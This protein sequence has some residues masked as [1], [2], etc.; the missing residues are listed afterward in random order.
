[1]KVVTNGFAPLYADKHLKIKLRDCSEGTVFVFTEQTTEYQNRLYKFV[2][3][4]LEN[5]QELSGWMYA[6][7]LDEYLENLPRNVVVIDNATE[8]PNDAWQYADWFGQKQTNLCGQICAA[9]VLGIDLKDILAEWQQDAPKNFESVF[10]LFSSKKARGT[11]IPDLQNL[12][13]VFDKIAIPL[14][15]VFKDANIPSRAKNAPYMPTKTHEIIRNYDVIAG[16]HINNN[17]GVLQASGTLHWVVLESVH[18]DRWKMGAVGIFN[19]FMNSI[20][21]YSWR[22]W[23]ASA[24]YPYGVAIKK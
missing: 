13:S 10:N 5:G 2:T 1:M 14:A 21:Y 3:R 6:G 7:Y 19:P 18:L 11:G 22:E 24:G 20:E 23:I 16:C 15:D 17:T 12:F 4:T 8:N 9:R